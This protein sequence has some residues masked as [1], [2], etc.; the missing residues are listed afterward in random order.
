MRKLC[1]LKC[2]L[3]RN[4]QTDKTE[5][6]Q[7][8][9][10]IRTV[11]VSFKRCITVHSLQDTVISKWPKQEQASGKIYCYLTKFLSLANLTRKHLKVRVVNTFGNSQSQ[12]SQILKSKEKLLSAQCSNVNPSRKRARKS[13]HEDLEDALLQCF[14]QAKSRGLL[15]SGP[16][17][18]E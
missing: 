18:H 10:N 2:A 14:K 3:L 5:F 9:V 7:S 17:L 12:V 8:H 16:M 6:K 1:Y 4:N 13:T 11:L 15:I